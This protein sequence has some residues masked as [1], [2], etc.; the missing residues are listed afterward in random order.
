MTGAL[1]APALTDG[2]D[3]FHLFSLCLRAL[4]P[5]AG[6]WKSGLCIVSIRWIDW[7]CCLG[8]NAALVSL[9]FVLSPRASTSTTEPSML[10]NYAAQQR[11]NGKYY[12]STNNKS[13]IYQDLKHISRLLRKVMQNGRIATERILLPL[14]VAF[15]NHTQHNTY[16]RMH[17]C[18][19]ARVFSMFQ[20]TCSL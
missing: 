7:C 17:L 2:R 6:I 9:R 10:N 1:S 13:T 19:L 20:R 12:L 11:L 16:M 8:P 15:R 18:S 14:R 3:H 4:F 5:L